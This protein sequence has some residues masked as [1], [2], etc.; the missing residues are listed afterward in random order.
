MDG[1]AVDSSSRVVTYAASEAAGA[2]ALC[3][4]NLKA[5]YV[6]LSDIGS[7]EEGRTTLSSAMNLCSPLSSTAD[8]KALLSYLQTP[9]FDLSEGSYP[10]PTDYITYA[11]TGSTNPL[12]AW[13]MQVMCEPLGTDFG[14]KISGNTSQ[15]DFTVAAG[16]V[17]VFVDWD[18]TSNNNY[19]QTDVSSSGALDLLSAAAQSIQVWYNVSGD[20]PSC[21]NWKALNSNVLGDARPLRSL[22]RQARRPYQRP[23]ILNKQEASV[24]K[25][26][27]TASATTCTFSSS[28]F[29][30]GTAWNALVCNEGINLVN[31]WAQG[32]GNDLYWPPNQEKG[33]TLD[34]LVPGSLAFCPYL[35]ELG[36]YGLPKKGDDWSFWLDTAYGGTRLQYASNIVYSNGN[37]DP[38]SPAGVDLTSVHTNK[39]ETSMEAPNKVRALSTDGSVVSVMIDMG[40]H[41]LDLFW[42]TDQDPESVRYEY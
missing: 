37:L 34:S 2:S 28:D 14:V 13:A 24:D 33:Y 9:L 31:W 35:S 11:L 1:C 16:N 18:K 12:P 30:A 6:L 40:G 27:S 17:E 23:T 20:Q 5:A 21:I 38:W 8:V 7:T 25:E 29:D 15:V 19:G 26:G 10:F 32:V 36:L 39:M 41:H 22:S 42:P 4:D 3:G